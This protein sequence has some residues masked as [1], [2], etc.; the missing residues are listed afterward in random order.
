[1]LKNKVVHREDQQADL[2]FNQRSLQTDYR[3]L[4]PL[5]K[6]GLRILDI[7]CGTGAISNDIAKAVGATGYVVAIDNTESFVK[8]GKDLFKE[9]SNLDLVHIDVLNYQPNPEDEKF[10]LIISSRTFQWISTI[11][12][13]LDKVKNWLKPGG[14]LSILD[15]DH[16]AIEWYPK[17]PDSMFEYYQT[18]LKWRADYGMNNSIGKDLPKLLAAHGFS[19]ITS[20]NAEETYYADQPDKLSIWSKVASSKQMVEDG[21]VVE[22]LRINAI[23][24]Y[25]NWIKEL[26]ESMKMQLWDTQATLKK[27]INNII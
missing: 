23:E 16:T 6:K 13:V 2:I 20:V 4:I 7:G 21:F 26:A 8:Q 1:M 27:E 10:D 25:N 11:E 22:E 18:F 12:Q 9:T 24:D 5:L 3:T 19:G 14:L 17:I 15:Y